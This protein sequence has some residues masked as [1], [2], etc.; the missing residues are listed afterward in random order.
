MVLLASFSMS[1]GRRLVIVADAEP[2][3]QLGQ[4]LDRLGGDPR[5]G[6][7][8]GVVA[9]GVLPVRMARPVHHATAVAASRHC[10]A[11]QRCRR[12]VMMR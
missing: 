6:G 9:H 3:R 2:E 12:G 8:F 11:A 7:H 5:D 10:Q 1:I 4:S